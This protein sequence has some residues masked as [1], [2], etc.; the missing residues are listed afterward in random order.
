[1]GSLEMN[2]IDLAHIF[3]IFPNYGEFKNLKIDFSSGNNFAKKIV[4]ERY[5]QLINK[6]IKR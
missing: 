6:N 1:M 2:L 4:N 3:T 5:I